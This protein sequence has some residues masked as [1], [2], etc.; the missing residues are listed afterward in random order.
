MNRRPIGVFDSGVGGLTVARA[1]AKALPN[2]DIIYL[3]DTARVP[4]GT[5]SKETVTRF[6]LECMDFLGKFNVKLAVMACNTASSWSL[7]T[8]REK[9]D[10]PVIGVIGPGVAEACGK[11]RNKRVGVIG[12]R[13]TITSGSYP[14]GIR[15][16][17]KSIKVYQKAC[18]LF[19]SLVEENWLN[20]R[21]TRDV[22][23]RYLE[24]MRRRGIDTLILGCTHYPLLKSV[25]KKIFSKRITIIDSSLSVSKEVKAFIRGN[26]LANR[27][28]RKGGIRFFVTDDPAAFRRVSGIFLKKNIL[29]KKVDIT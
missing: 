17:D 14:R 24:T 26:G 19:V 7:E 2:E 28:G 12:T 15:K 21:I 18:P 1:L 25:V 6:A 11:T 16:L 20:G 29:V 27:T 22:A 9:F 5:K 4:Y 3:G 23:A 8:V 13:A 10:F